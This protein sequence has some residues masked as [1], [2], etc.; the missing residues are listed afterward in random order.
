[1]YSLDRNCIKLG[2][3]KV[4]NHE[5]GVVCSI[6]K[7]CNLISVKK[8]TYAKLT[9]CEWLKPVS[10]Y[11]CVYDSLV[12]GYLQNKR[13]AS[14]LE[15]TAFSYIHSINLIRVIQRRW[16]DSISNPSF[17]VCKQRLLKEYV[18]LIQQ[19]DTNSANTHANIGIGLLCDH[20]GNK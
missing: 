18:D 15:M 7:P 2:I 5:L 13:N 8:D 11:C 12:N 3:V 17:R 10:I 4:C 1:M 20:N 19:T 16:R 9:E 14:F 6:F